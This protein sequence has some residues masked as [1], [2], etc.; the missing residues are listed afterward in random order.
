MYILILLL[1]SAP[2]FF[3]RL[4]E[5]SLTNWD[6][7][8]YAE[9]AKQIVLTGDF[10]VMRFGGNVFT[11]HP[12]AGF[13]FIAISQSIFGINELGTRVSGAVFG[14]ICILGVYLLGKRL[15]S[16][17]VGFC[18]SLAMLSAPW[19]VLRAR[20]GNL[21]VFLVT[22]FVWSIYLAFKATSEK[23]YLSHLS[24]SLAL[25]FLS[26]TMIP[27]TILPALF[28]ILYGDREIKIKDYFRP[29]G[30]FLAF[31]LPWVVLNFFAKPDF[32]QRYFKIGLPGVK[33]D[34]NP[35]ENIDYV[36]NYLHYGIGKFFWPGVIG[37]IGGFVTLQKRFVV[38]FIM[39]IT[40]LVPFVFSE[41]S[42]IWHMIPIYPFMF[43]LLFGFGEWIGKKI[44][45]FR[46]IVNVGMV[47][48]T[49]LIFVPQ[50]RA[51]WYNFIDT[52]AYI[53]D[54]A[55]LSKKAGEYE[56]PLFIDGDFVP[57]A[58]FYSSKIVKN[59][60]GNLQEFFDAND[61]FLLITKEE[62]LISE[63]KDDYEV[64]ARDRDKVLIVV[65]K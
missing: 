62:R 25:L 56:E 57:V 64:I 2:I 22:F 23:K 10:L 45:R 4:A 33:T 34:N 54:E 61:N 53:S 31:T 49:L 35:L 7:A 58:T 16:K 29:V 8:W 24:V 14:M 42:H 21:D 13:W 18:A 27:F 20:S 3:H 32:I 50:A 41:K 46:L 30:F 37:A 19:F 39:I 5:S 28:L 52:P 51:N 47:A 26:K 40:L 38:L 59:A 11:D 55:I 48:F 60:R 9:I 6:E 44:L 1:I 15:F 36:S 12:P 65:K 63:V 17:T 43:L